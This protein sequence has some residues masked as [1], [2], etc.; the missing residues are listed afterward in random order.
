[1][2]SRML[3][4]LQ[5]NAIPHA[6]CTGRLSYYGSHLH[7][8]PYSTGRFEGG[9]FNAAGGGFNTV[10]VDLAP[11]STPV[12]HRKVIRIDDLQQLLFCLLPSAKP[13]VSDGI[14]QFAS[15]LFRNSMC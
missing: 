3:A 11:T 4:A 13:L 2:M 9:G 8:P 14:K 6:P 10:G 12:L 5:F 1:M 15:M 7:Q